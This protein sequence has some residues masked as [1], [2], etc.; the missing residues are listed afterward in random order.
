MNNGFN[1]SHNNF[2]TEK[3]QEISDLK[4]ACHG[5]STVE[6]LSRGLAGPEAGLR[7]VTHTNPPQETNTTKTKIWSAVIYNEEYNQVSLS[8]EHFVLM[9]IERENKIIR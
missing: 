8:A 4:Y 1:G 7:D 6:Y 9:A 2:N 5:R 3:N